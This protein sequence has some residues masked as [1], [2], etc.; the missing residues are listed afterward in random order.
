MRQTPWFTEGSIEFLREFLETG[1][2][3]ILEFGM[4][5]STVWLSKRCNSIVSVEHDSTWFQEVKNAVGDSKSVQ[6]ILAESP[7][8]GDSDLLEI[9][10]SYIANSFSD[11]FFDALII[12]GRS[13][14][15][16]FIHAERKL[17]TGGLLILDNS[18]RPEYQEIFS[19]YKDKKRFDFIQ[20]N[21]DSED[22]TYPDWTTTCWI[23]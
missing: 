7:V 11:N 1:T 8:I 14:V 19:A 6:L 22:F 12:D 5:A 4:G 10:Y 20:K 18:E 21:P 2:K 9:S 16:C 13:R 17:N 3:N 15:D 23:K